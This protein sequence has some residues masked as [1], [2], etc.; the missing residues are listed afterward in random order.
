MLN[1]SALMLIAGAAIFVLDASSARGQDTTRTRRRPT[2]TRRIP[3]TKEAASPGEVTVRVDTVVTYRTDTLRVPG[4]PDT[5]VTTR[6]V[7]RVDTV[8][9]MIPIKVPQIGGFYAGLAVGSS[10]PAASFNNSDH[11]GW[12][13]EVPFG[14]DFVDTPWGIRFNAGYANYSPHSWVSFL[15][16]A[17]IWNIDGGVKLRI[18]SA[19]PGLVRLQLYGLASGSYNR[20]KNILEDDNGLLSIGDSTRRTTLPLA[21][22]TD[23]HSGW[24]WNAGAGLEVGKGHTNVFVEVRY[25]RFN[26]V[27]TNISSV[28]LVIGVNW[29]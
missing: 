18:A 26:G 16:N 2:S 28:P 3:V 25:N 9:Q 11:P 10:M 15:D 22:D 6:T 7:T 13:F 29:F 17:Q 8:T 12:R 27:N 20:F 23:W 4:K 5:V 19:T 21:V 24:G 14:F 1:R